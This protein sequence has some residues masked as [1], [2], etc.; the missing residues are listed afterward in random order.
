GQSRTQ[1]LAPGADQVGRHLD[2]ER[3]GRL[4][5]FPQR[6]VDPDEVVGGRG[7]VTGQFRGTGRPQRFSRPRHA[8]TVGSSG[9]NLQAGGG[10]SLTARSLRADDSPAVPE[11]S[12][13]R[14]R[15]PS[16]AD[17]TENVL[18]RTRSKRYERRI[19]T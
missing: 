3:I 8:P 15:S 16:G 18:L 1:S 2:E 6:G 11:T 19:P 7:P 5:R 17:Y 14:K 4:H 13:M 12:W 9:N 10:C